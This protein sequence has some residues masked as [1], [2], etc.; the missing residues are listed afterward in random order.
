MTTRTACWTVTF[1]HPFVLSCLDGPQPAGSH[2]VEADEELLEALSFPAHRRVEMRLRVRSAGIER[3]ARVDPEELDAALARDKQG[4]ALDIAATQSTMDQWPL[5]SS[6][7]RSESAAAVAAGKLQNAPP[8][9]FAP[10]RKG[11]VMTTN[12][13]TICLTMLGIFPLLG[14]IAKFVTS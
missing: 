2:V 10:T 6:H 12:I 7:R 14:G 5:N 11:P 13:F 1:A 8:G 4:A 9:V 3:V